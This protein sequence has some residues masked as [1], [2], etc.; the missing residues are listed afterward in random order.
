MRVNRVLVGVHG[1]AV[2]LFLAACGGPNPGAIDPSLH[3][4]V[5]TRPAVGPKPHQQVTFTFSTTGTARSWII[6]KGEECSPLTLVTAGSKTLSLLWPSGG[7]CEGPAPRGPAPRE[8]GLLANKPSITWSGYELRTHTAC[9]D[10]E[11]QGYPGMGVVAHTEATSVAAPAGSYK[12][13]FGVLDTAPLD[14]NEWSTGDL[15]CDPRQ[16]YGRYPGDPEHCPAD[17]T[18]TVTFTL[19]ASGDL[20]VPVVVPPPTP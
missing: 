15:S 11:S 2:L 10:C 4:C 3:G 9:E 5:A 8:A 20:T 19:P 17:R 1:A 12:A 16:G 7:I 18:V 14:C 6:T 13:T